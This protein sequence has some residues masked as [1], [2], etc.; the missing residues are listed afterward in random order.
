MF[1]YHS[2]FFLLFCTAFFRVP[3]SS[4]ADITPTD[5][6][7]SPLT[8]NFSAAA[9]SAADSAMSSIDVSSSDALPTQ[10]DVVRKTDRITKRL[11]ELFISAQEGNPSWYALCAV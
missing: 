5:A 6:V 11:Q 7:L 3:P 2:D 10:D 4:S 8:S 1:Y 9:D